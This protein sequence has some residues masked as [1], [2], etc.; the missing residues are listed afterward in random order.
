MSSE[1][2]IFFALVLITLVIF[3]LIIRNIKLRKNKFNLKDM[4]EQFDIREMQVK[5]NEEAVKQNK[6]IILSYEIKNKIDIKKEPTNKIDE[7]YSVNNN[8]SNVPK[9]EYVDKKIESIEGI[10]P[11]Y[12]KKLNE[13]GIFTIKDL[14]KI[15]ND[16]DGLKKINE[17]TGIYTKLLEK[18]RI[19]ADFLRIQGIRNDQID[20]LVQIGI[21][22]T[23]LMISELPDSIHRKLLEKYA[24]YEIPTIS[25]IKRWRR[26]S[27]HI[28]SMD[29]VK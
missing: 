13:C 18:W 8:D 29:E 7:K 6:N 27:E 2:A 26:I 5:K 28:K 23:S 11:S 25:M 24:Y 1:Q 20:Q 22:S 19:K 21:K 3:I 12:K 14:V 16:L 15:S 9:Y 17:K 4:Y 10:G